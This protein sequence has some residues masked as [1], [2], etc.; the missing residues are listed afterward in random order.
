MAAA[1]IALASLDITGEIIG[2]LDVFELL[3]VALTCSNFRE[4]AR[5]V[6]HPWGLRSKLSQ[7]VSN[8][9]LLQWALSMGG[10]VSCS[11]K[12]LCA[13]AARFGSLST[14]QWLLEKSDPPCPLNEL[15]CEF[16]SEGGH[17]EVW[18]S[19]VLCL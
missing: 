6:N 13:H 2:Y 9:P 10:T 7:F 3:P 1:A 15:C 19:I 5:R 12:C 8:I 16:A 4:A 18:L 17:F 11:Q 14:L